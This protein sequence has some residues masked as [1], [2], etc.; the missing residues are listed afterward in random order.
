M[1]VV[2]WM[3]AKLLPSLVVMVR[4]LSTHA[5]WTEGFSW[6]DVSDNSYKFVLNMT[7]IWDTFHVLWDTFHVLLSGTSPVIFPNLSHGH[8]VFKITPF[9]CGTNHSP[10]TFFADI[11]RSFPEPE[12][13]RVSMTQTI[14]VQS[15]RVTLH[16]SGSGP[17]Q[18]F[19]CY[20]DRGGRVVRNCEWSQTCSLFCLTLFSGRGL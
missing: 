19:T 1:V 8:H 10:V 7:Q 11:G 3:E 6:K 18:S 4:S 12:I 20:V 14:A 2:C 5:S 17:Y 16:F 15:N 9:G 13:C